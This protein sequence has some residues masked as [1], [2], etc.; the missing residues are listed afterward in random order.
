MKRRY[1]IDYRNGNK[2]YLT[3][4]GTEREIETKF[5]AKLAIVNNPVKA[6]YWENRKGK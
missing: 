5:N 3:L 1:T 4:T 2:E 6:I